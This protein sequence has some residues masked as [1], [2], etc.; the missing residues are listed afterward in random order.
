MTG[1]CKVFDSLKMLLCGQHFSLAEQR[2]P[3]GWLAYASRWLAVELVSFADR[4]IALRISVS[5]LMFCNL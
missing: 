4:E 2:L 3:Q 1:H 5:A